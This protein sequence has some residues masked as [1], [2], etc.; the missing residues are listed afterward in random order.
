MTLSSV[1][2]HFSSLADILDELI[3]EAYRRATACFVAEGRPKDLEAWLVGGVIACVDWMTTDP[4]AGHLIA[5]AGGIPSGGVRRI[6]TVHA[7]VDRFREAVA[8]QVLP[9]A[10]Y[11]TQ[12]QA[13][14]LAST[15]VSLISALRPMARAASGTTPGSVAENGAVI[16]RRIAV[17]ADAGSSR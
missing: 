2:Y 10:G 11:L 5:G 13:W 7:C 3:E 16:A 9:R 14:L 8:E 4:F 1:Y 17:W 6:A 12:E 15:V